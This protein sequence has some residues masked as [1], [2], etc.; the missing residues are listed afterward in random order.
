MFR[1]KTRDRSPSGSATDHYGIGELW[2]RRTCGGLIL[3]SRHLS[4]TMSKR[5]LP[6]LLQLCAN[7]R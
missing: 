4:H 5:A 2:K 3:L 7:L 6:N 1:E